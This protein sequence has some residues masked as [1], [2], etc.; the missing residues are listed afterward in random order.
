MNPPAIWLAPFLPTV[1]PAPRQIA[2]VAVGNV[3]EDDRSADSARQ[4]QRR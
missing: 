4:F 1:K 3:R 2:R